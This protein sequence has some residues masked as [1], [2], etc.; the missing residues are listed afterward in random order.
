VQKKGHCGTGGECRGM[1]RSKKWKDVYLFYEKNKDAAYCAIN[2]QR[3]IDIRPQVYDKEQGMWKR[4]MSYRTGATQYATLYLKCDG[5]GCDTSNMEDWMLLGMPTNGCTNEDGKPCFQETKVEPIASGSGETDQKP[6]TG[7]RSRSPTMSAAE[8][9]NVAPSSVSI[10][11]INSIQKM[12]IDQYYADFEKCVYNLKNLKH[13]IILHQSVPDTNEFD[14]SITYRLQNH[15][16]VD[17]AQD[18]S[19][20]LGDC[21]HLYYQIEILD[22]GALKFHFACRS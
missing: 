14:Q 6:V 21:T 15:T 7:K 13:G 4:D 11:A 8:K 3:E 9:Q 10:N 16:I 18:F 17:I 12:S 19:I 5:C 20:E 1:L 22:D 2:A